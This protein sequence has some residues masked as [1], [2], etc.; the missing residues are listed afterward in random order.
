MLAAAAVVLVV[1]AIAVLMLQAAWRP[2]VATPRQAL[3]AAA[4]RLAAQPRGESSYWR[5][6]SE[7]LQRTKGVDGYLVEERGLDVL[8]SGPDGDVYTWYEAVS[9]VPYG[10][11]GA[12]T[13]RRVGSPRLCP[14]AAATGT[15]AT[16]RAASW[17]STPTGHPARGRQSGR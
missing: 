6:E 7:E 5:L 10:E 3:A 15:C 12:E 11:K 4:D 16:T 14:T 1:G 13:W 8:A 9:A 17:S 2:V